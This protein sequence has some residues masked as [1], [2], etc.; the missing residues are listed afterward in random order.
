MSPEHGKAVRG[1]K[2]NSVPAWKSGHKKT[3]FRWKPPRRQKHVPEKHSGSAFGTAERES[4]AHGAANRESFAHGTADR[5]PL[6][7]NGTVSGSAGKFSAG[8]FQ[9][10]P[11]FCLLALWF[12]MVN[13]WKLLVM[14]LWTVAVHESGHILTLALSGAKITGLHIGI[15]GAVLRTDCNRLSYGRELCA[16]LSGPVANLLFATALCVDGNHW[17]ALTGANLLLCAYNLL[18]VRPLD[19]GRAL[20]LIVSWAMGPTI[21]ERVSRW[22]GSVTAAGITGALIFIMWKSGGSLWLMPAAFA[23]GECAI[24]EL[25]GK[26][27]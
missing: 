26:E 22:T 27:S 20:H 13:G 9:I 7:H 8:K 2:R 24:R 15:C 12:G 5:E 11:E 6:Q 21:G 23:M 17:P 25:R 10:S 16:A 3:I 19:G 4:F 14:I 18:P 1:I